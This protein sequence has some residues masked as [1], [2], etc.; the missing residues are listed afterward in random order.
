MEKAKKYLF[1][2]PLAEGDPDVL[3]SGNVNVDKAGEITFDTDS[4]HLVIA[5]QSH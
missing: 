3:L 5:S 4:G 1:F 2:R